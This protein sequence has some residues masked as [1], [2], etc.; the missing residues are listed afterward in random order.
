MYKPIMAEDV[1]SWYQL[2]FRSLGGRP[3]IALLV[4]KE[5]MAAEP[6]HASAGMLRIHRRSFDLPA[7]AADFSEGLGFDGV[8]R[9]I[10]E[11]GDFSVFAAGLPRIFSLSNTP[12]R[13]CDGTGKDDLNETCLYCMGR[14]KE[15]EENQQPARAVLTSLAVLTLWLSSYKAL[16]TSNLPQ[17]MTLTVIPGDGTDS[18]ALSGEFSEALVKWLMRSPA[19]LVRTAVVQAMKLSWKEMMS[20]EER[21]FAGIRVEQGR[22]HINVPG[23]ASGLDPNGRAIFGEGYPV[24]GHNLDSVAQQ[25]TVI[26]GLAALH[27]LVRRNS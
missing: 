23:D 20:E 19:T 13:G 16:T 22:L 2:S 5:F 11:E 21:G 1:P 27:D 8:F 4:H 14:K 25:L 9:N 3:S 7:F 26:A 17:L 12:C 15:V 6:L 10:G 18:G 24:A